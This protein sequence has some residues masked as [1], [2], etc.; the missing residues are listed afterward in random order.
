MPGVG[1]SYTIFKKVVDLA[2]PVYIPIFSLKAFLALEKKTFKIWPS[3]LIVQNNLNKLTISLQQK[4]SCEIYMY[5]TKRQGQIE[6]RGQQYD[7]N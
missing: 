3:C 4:I 2:F 7:C 5:I 1:P 6:S